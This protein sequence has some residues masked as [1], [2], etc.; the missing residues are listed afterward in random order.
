MLN[1]QS[2]HTSDTRPMTNTSRLNDRDD[3]DQMIDGLA[4]LTRQRVDAGFEPSLLSFMFARLPGSPSAVVRRMREEATRVYSALITRV[5]RDPRRSAGSLPIMIASPDAPVPKRSRPLAVN[6]VQNGGVHM[7]GVLLLPPRSRLKTTIAEHF[8]ANEGIYLG[9]TLERI[10]VRP[11][12]HAPERVVDYVLKGL[13]R[14]RFDLDD[15][16]ILPRSISELA[17]K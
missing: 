2:N 9:R 14:R 16:L 12:T 3:I 15:V 5:V 13:R 1:Q 4:E 7:H 17:D 10:D 8:N 6:V 11:I